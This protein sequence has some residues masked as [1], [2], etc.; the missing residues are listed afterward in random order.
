MTLLNITQIKYYR[1]T[2]N[3]FDHYQSNTK[4]GRKL[5]KNTHNTKKH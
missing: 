1:Q 5:D 2:M 4:S 3:Y